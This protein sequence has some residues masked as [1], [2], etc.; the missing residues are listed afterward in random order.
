MEELRLND[1]RR[2][3]TDWATALGPDR[4]AVLVT[5]A[6]TGGP[7]RPDGTPWPANAPAVC[8]AFPGFA[9]A[10]TFGSAAV[11]AAPGVR[12]DVYDHRG[13]SVPPLRTFV[14]RETTARADRSR[15]RMWLAVLG[16]LAV[17]APLFAW[18]YQHHGRLFLPT[19]F[20]I[21]CLI[22]AARVAYTAVSLGETDRV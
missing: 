11:A 3:P 19:L 5:D 21:N 7:I 4:V 20:G 22:V 8:Y 9:D 1:P 15:K 10:E 12:C 17:A 16:L 2:R 18:D 14:S 6:R 13:K